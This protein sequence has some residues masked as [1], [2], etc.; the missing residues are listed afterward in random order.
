MHHLLAGRCQPLQ[1]GFGRISCWA[2]TGLWRAGGV[3]L[4]GV[5]SHLCWEVE[6][7]L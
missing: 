4:G 3:D 1:P 2:D 7:C 5:S 6:L